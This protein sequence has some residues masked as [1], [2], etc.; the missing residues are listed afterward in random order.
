MYGSV[1]SVEEVTPTEDPE[2]A[3]AMGEITGRD[4]DYAYDEQLGEDEELDTAEALEVRP[5]DI[6]EKVRLLRVVARAESGRDGYSAINPDNE[7][8]NPRHPAYHHYHIGL[9]FGF[10]QFTQRSGLL[11]KV[12]KAA[13]ARA[14]PTVVASDRFETLFGADWRG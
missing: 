8:N 1:T 12:L 4:P 5:L 6:A 11:G 7:Y 3:G 14:L 10:I 2:L 9:S 13:R